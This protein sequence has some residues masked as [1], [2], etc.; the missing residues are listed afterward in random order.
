MQECTTDTSVLLGKFCTK[1]GVVRINSELACSSY[2]YTIVKHDSGF[3]V[4]GKKRNYMVDNMVASCSCKFNN[5]NGL[6]CR[7]I[8]AVRRHSKLEM[9][10]L[11]MIPDRWRKIAMRQSHSSN[12]LEQNDN[13]SKPIITA[14]RVSVLSQSE[15]YCKALPIIKDFANILSKCGEREFYEKLT[16]LENVRKC[17]REGNDVT[18]FEECNTMF[19]NV[20]LMMLVLMLMLIQV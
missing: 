9:L 11:D 5:D 6:P 19:L 13:T 4:I 14:K 20:I 3:T 7:H 2:K 16:F 18:V 8:F 1:A 17:W 10:T 12:D 15:K